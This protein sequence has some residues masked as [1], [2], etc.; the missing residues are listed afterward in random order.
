MKILGLF[1]GISCGQ[2]ALQRLGLT[3]DVYYASEIDPYAISVTQK[4]FPNTIQLGDVKLWETWDIDWSDIDFLL[5]GFPCQAWSMAGRR[6][7]KEDPRGQ[8]FWDM[9]NIAKFALQKNPNIKFIFEN[10]VMSKANEDMLTDHLISEL[11][12]NIVRTRINSS[13]MCAQNRE[14]NYW[15]NFEIDPANKVD[16]VVLRDIWDW[17]VPAY[18]YKLADVGNIIPHSKKH[19]VNFLSLFDAERVK[20]CKSVKVGLIKI[21]EFENTRNKKHGRVAQDGRFYSI[22]GKCTTIV[23][24]SHLVYGWIDSE[25]VYFRQLTPLEFERVQ[26]VPDNYTAGLSM[27]QRKIVLGNGWTVGIISHIFKSGLQ[28]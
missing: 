15:T 17:S 5:G 23:T 3:P 22:D 25:Y 8:L 24:K 20:S 1:D 26:M 14:R 28:I 2:L 7:G 11:G 27:T 4:H 9:T 21:G 13:V 10:V 16:D 6:K 19:N 18:K 12:D